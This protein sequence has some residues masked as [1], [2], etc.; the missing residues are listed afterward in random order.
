[1]FLNMQRRERERSESPDVIR[2]NECRQTF[3]HYYEYCY[4]DNH[5]CSYASFPCKEWAE[6]GD[7]GCKEI[8]RLHQIKRAEEEKIEQARKDEQS[9]KLEEEKRERKR[10]WH[11]ARVGRPPIKK[12]R[13]KK[14]K[15]YRYLIVLFRL[16]QMYKEKK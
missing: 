16:F 9:A 5:D 11:L 13:C 10:L 7:C 6:T 15:R 14:A 2:C 12:R 8:E 3:E 4:H 1:M